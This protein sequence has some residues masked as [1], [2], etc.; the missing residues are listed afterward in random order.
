MSRS[1][2]TWAGVVS[3]LKN[4]CLNRDLI[5][6]KLQN[7]FVVSFVSNNIVVVEI[8]YQITRYPY[9]R[10]DKSLFTVNITKRR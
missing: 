7:G 5:M 6:C 2:M 9:Q 8:S 3:L 4:P 1:H 10:V